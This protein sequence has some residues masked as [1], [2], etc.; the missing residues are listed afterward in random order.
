M[1]ADVVSAHADKNSLASQVLEASLREEK[2]AREKLE[3]LVEVQQVQVELYRSLKMKL[4]VLYQA[5]QEKVAE[6]S[7]ELSE[8]SEKLAERTEER[9]SSQRSQES[10]GGRTVASRPDDVRLHIVLQSKEKQLDELSQRH[11]DLQK[12]SADGKFELSLLQQEVATLRAEEV[13]RAAELNKSVLCEAQLRAQIFELRDERQ[14]LQDLLAEERGRSSKVA[15]ALEDLQ[16][17]RKKKESL[18][19]KLAETTR[20]SKDEYEAL[21]KETEETI[22]GREQTIRHQTSAIEA[23][24]RELKEKQV[25]LDRLTE[26]LAKGEPDTAPKVKPGVERVYLP[27]LGPKPMEDVEVRRAIE[28]LRKQLKAKDTKLEKQTERLQGLGE[29]LEERDTQLQE[30]LSARRDREKLR[31]RLADLE[32]AMKSQKKVMSRADAERRLIG[33]EARLKES[34]RQIQELGE[35]LQKERHE[36][37]AV[38]CELRALEERVKHGTV[39]AES[40]DTANEAMSKE[41]AVHQVE[42]AAKAEQVSHLQ[43]VLAESQAE[44]RKLSERV[45]PEPGEVAPLPALQRRLRKLEE[46]DQTLARDVLVHLQDREHKIETLASTVALLR[47]TVDDLQP[48]Q[49]GGL[50]QE[51][52]DNTAK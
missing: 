12:E 17:E 14:R 19:Q 11:Q 35:N 4:E 2:D 24:N 43:H 47:Q 29:L 51:G 15:E 22:Q 33:Q 28:G 38:T 13:D 23:L 49:E 5:E 40:M 39:S 52:R 32:D 36:R 7:K 37:Q 16:V 8:A 1:A 44:V 25:E 46:A 34:E 6:L 30:L 26:L 48:E 20:E 27:P 41:L 42:L 18:E 9:P 21:C 45:V 31:I 10:T 3:K 50:A